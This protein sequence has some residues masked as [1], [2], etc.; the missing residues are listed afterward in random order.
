MASV[1]S[2]AGGFLIP[3]LT[4][5]RFSYKHKHETTPGGWWLGEQ[6]L[7]PE[8]VSETE[9]FIV[10]K[11]REAPPPSLSHRCGCWGRRRSLAT[12]GTLLAS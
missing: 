6:P 12:N 3:G 8:V 10:V 11:A 1:S 9:T 7:P 2:R 4:P 5:P